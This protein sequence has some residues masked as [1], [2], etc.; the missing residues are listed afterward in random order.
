MRSRFLALLVF[1]F[2]CLPAFSQQAR[3]FRSWDSHSVVTQSNVVFSEMMQKVVNTSRGPRLNQGSNVVL[4]G[5][6]PAFIFPAAGSAAAFRTETVLVNRR[7]RSQR[8]NL[9]FLPLG[10]GAANCVLPG[11]ALTLDAESTNLFPDFV[12]DVFG[13]SGQ[14]GSVVVVGVD[15]RDNPDTGAAIDG[16][17]RIYS[18]AAGGGT[19]SQNFPSFSVLGPNGGQSAFG[20]RSDEFYRT[21]WGIF[22][23]DT[24]DR[25]FDLVF[26]GFRQGSDQTIARTIPACTLVQERVPGGPYGSLEIFFIPRDGGGS[27]YAYGSTVDNVSSDSYSVPARR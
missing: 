12:T 25:V 3:A 2:V 8:I 4:E 6:E 17:A 22:N 7:N 15:S 18:L 20:L 13:A 26:S 9:F 1:A 5:A 23:Y 10:G 11:R 16:N 21:N 14:F 27:Y 24:R 19:V